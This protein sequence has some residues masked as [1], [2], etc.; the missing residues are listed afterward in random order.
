MA[1]RRH[2]FFHQGLENFAKSKPGSWYYLHIAPPVDRVLM[3]V[4]GGRLNANFGFPVLVLHNKGAKSGIVRET[5][6]LY[7]M[8]GDNVIV[9]AS[10]AGSPK[11]PGWYHNLKAHPEVEVHRKG[12]VEQRRARRGRGRGV[13][14]PLGRGEPWLR[15][16]RDLPG[17]GRRAQDPADGARAAL[18]MELGLDTKVVLLAAGLT[19]L[20]ALALGIWKYRQMS[21]PPD[22]QAHFYVNTAHRAAL[23]YAFAI[24][25]LAVFVQF[26]AWSETVDLIAALLPIFF[27]LAA[28]FSYMVQGIRAQTDNTFRDGAP[29]LHPFMYSLIVAEIGG[30]RGAARRLRNRAVLAGQ[31]P[32]AN[33]ASSDMRSGVHGGVKTMW[34]CTSLTPSS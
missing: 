25:M 29:G 33:F 28:I 2:N 24:T 5:P 7:A 10:K 8:D 32:S 31:Y 34:D 9:V 16:V 15:R 12:K 30:V 17:P 26:S 23:L 27:F 1:E 3:K 13:R 21:Q 19:F 22:H 18:G 14:A 11:N 4:S 20:W 6:L